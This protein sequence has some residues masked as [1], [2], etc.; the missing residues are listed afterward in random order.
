MTQT[1]R[2]YGGSLYDL[3][4]EEKL[5]EQILEQMKEIRRIFSENPEYVSLLGQPSIPK[6]ERED[7]IEK[8][9]GS[10]AERY[11]VN[12]IKLLCDRSILMEFAGCCE[13][14]TRRYHA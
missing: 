12:F 7:M 6:K 3:A 1:A 5:T 8:A 13:E 9:F 10:Q 2:V 11:L 4:A 14:F